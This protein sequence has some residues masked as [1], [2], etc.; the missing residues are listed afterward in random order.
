MSDTSQEAA[1]GT[2]PNEPH[3]VVPK[4]AYPN[5]P[6]SAK[7]L[8]KW[9][10]GALKI[11]MA[12]ELLMGIASAFLLW[13]YLPDT[14][15]P[16]SYE[17]LTQ[18]D[19]AIAAIAILQ[20][21]S[22]MFC[23]VMVSRVTYRTMRNLHTIG[24]KKAEMSPAWAVGWYFIPFANLWKPAE[25]MSQIYHG[26]YAA[27]GEKSA[28]N[29]PIPLWWTFWLVSNVTANISMRLSGGFN[30]EDYSSTTFGL[31]VASSL[32]GVASAYLLLRLLR[33][34]VDRQEAFKHGGMMTVFD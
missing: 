33:R 8:F 11:Y 32:F 6:R 4:H 14:V 30:G 17:V 34:V 3:A 5:G 1:R 22:L 13:L 10:A 20:F 25:G 15:A 16:V 24:S 2:E 7:S 12:A 29:S 31:D 26:T 23:Y 28:A 18:F 21:T 9:L 27:M 19:L